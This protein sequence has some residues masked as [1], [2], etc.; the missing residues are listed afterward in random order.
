MH[1]DM[2]DG[3]SFVLETEDEL[4]RS[5]WHGGQLHA[6][7]AWFHGMVTPVADDEISCGYV[8]RYLL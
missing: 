4:T 1:F 5:Q 7:A 8:A 2:H 6:D 3:S